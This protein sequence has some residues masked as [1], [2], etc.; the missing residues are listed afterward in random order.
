[1]SSSSVSEV[2]CY[3]FPCLQDIALYEN[4]N[5]TFWRRVEQYG[6]GRMYDDVIT[7]RNK[8]DEKRAENDSRK[9]P[10]ISPVTLGRR[11]RSIDIHQEIYASVPK[12]LS[13]EYKLSVLRSKIERNSR[14]L[15]NR[16]I[17]RL[18]NYMTDNHGW[19]PL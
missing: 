6:R 17:S 18:A 3:N 11:R 2:I 14:G 5:A 4:F 7:L 19:C 15:T 12:T 10:E 16:Q 1:M 8:R 13:K 9:L